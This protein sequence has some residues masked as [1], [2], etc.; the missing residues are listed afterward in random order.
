MV[1]AKFINEINAK[2]I[3]LWQENGQL[4]FKAA[5]GAWTD[6]V[7][8][9]VIA[10]KKEIIEFLCQRSQKA[11]VPAILPVTR[12][13]EDGSPI[14]SFPLSF[15][16]ER[17]W[18]IDQLEPGSTGY[19]L[20]VAVTVS[21]ELNIELLEQAFN[22]LI[23]RHESLRTVFATYEGTAQQVILE[24]IAFKLEHVDLSNHKNDEVLHQE[25][26]QL[27]QAEAA[28]PFDLSKGPLIRGKLFKLSEKEHVLMLIKHHIISDGWSMGIMIKEL[29]LMMRSL[30][31]GQSPNLPPLPVQYVDYSAW[32]RKWLGDGGLLEKQLAYWSEKLAG[33]PESLNL[34]TDYP[35]L[36]VQ[37]VEGDKHS[38]SLDTR[39]TSKL[40]SMAE[41][42]GCTL[43]MVLVAAFNALL[44]RY[45]GQ[46]DIC[47]GSPVANRHYGE[48]EGLIGLFI[49]TLAIR[50]QVKGDASFIALLAQVK[51]TCLA[52]YKHQDTPF[53]KIVDTVQP[54]RSTAINPIFQIMIGLHNERMEEL[55]ENIRRYPIDVDS[56]KLDLTLSFTEH[57]T[58]INGAV[59]YKTSLFKPQTIER[60]TKHFVNICQA[61][62]CAPEVNISS[63]EFISEAEKQLLLTE[64]NQ[65]QTSYPNDKCIHQLFSEQVKSNP[66]K[67]AVVF[68]D[69]TMSYQQL[70]DK[71]HAL[72][73][74]LQS[75]GVKPD[76]LVG[77]C[78]ERS[79]DMMV[80][81][82][83]ILQA[84]AAYLPLDPDLPDDRLTFMLEDSEAAII[85]TQE[86]LRN[87]LS[88]LASKDTKL[89]ALDQQWSE[90][91]L[92][93]DELKRKQVK[94]QQLVKPHHLAYVI[95]TSGSTGQ[96]K[97][98]MIE[99]RM[100]ID[101]CYAVFNKLD[102]QHCETFGAV[103][104]FS[105]DLGNISLFVPVMFSKTIVMFS[106]GY[107]NNPPKLKH[108]LDNNLV[109]FMKITPSHFEMFKISDSEIV[110]PAKV[111]IF[112]G[113]PL[114][115][116]MVEVVNSL[117]PGCRV[118][119]N[120]GP[121]ETTISKLSTD[122]LISD[123]ISSINLGKPLSNT[124]VYILD[125][126]KNLVPTGVPG[127]LYIA[128]EGVA[129]GY[130]NR[131]EL[132][133][134]NFLVNPFNTEAADSYS[135]MYKTGDLVRWLDDGNIEYLGRVDT[136][137]KI[138]GFRIEVGEI[139]AQ[140]NQ[141]PE[142]KESIVTVSGQDS[143]KKL[144]AYYVAKETKEG[145][146]INLV[147][148]TLRS[149]LQQ[150]LP[151]YML[152]TTF[153]SLESMPLT[154]SGKA[155]RRA[156]QYIDVS[157]ESSNAYVAPRNS[158][159]KQLVVIWADVLN[160]EEEKVGIKDNFFELGGDSIKIIQVVYSASKYDIHFDANDVFDYQ[161]I[162]E[163]V[164]NCDTT[165]SKDIVREE[166]SLQGDV[167]LSPIQS[168]FFEH[169]DKDVHHYNQAV[170]L[171]L[172][173]SLSTTDLQEIA[174]TLIQQHDALRLRY[175]KGDSGWKQYYSGSI[176]ETL[177]PEFHTYDI[178][179]LEGE[180]LA[181]YVE[182]ICN[183]WQVSL[184]LE[185]G[186]IMKWVCFE[187]KDNGCDQ[188]AIIIHHLAIDGVSWRILFD[189]FN[190]LIEQQLA[191]ESLDLDQK[192]SSYRDWVD[193]L[194]G[195]KESQQGKMDLKFWLEQSERATSS[196]S[197]FEENTLADKPYKVHDIEHTSV[198]LSK[199]D[200]ERLLKHCHQAYG[201]NINDL[202][203]TALMTSY[204]HATGNQNLTVD[205]EGHGRELL[206]PDIDITKTLGWFTSIYPVYFDLSNP[207]NIGQCIKDVKSTLHSIPSKGVGYS[208]FRYID[209]HKAIKKI[210]D[211]QVVFNFLGD[212]ST[213]ENKPSNNFFTLSK[214]SV[215]NTISQQRN[216]KSAVT[217]NG[218]VAFD[219][220]SFTFQYPKEWQGQKI[221]QWQTCF[222]SALE[223]LI[224]QCYGSPRLGFTPD[225][226]SL[227]SASPIQV[228]NIVQS[229]KQQ[230][231]TQLDNIQDIYPL[232]PLQS[233]ILF[234]T[235][236]AQVDDNKGMYLTQSVIGINDR[237]DIN[238][239][240]RAWKLIANHYDALRMM[241][242]TDDVAN[243]NTGLQVI[244]KQVD[245]KIENFDWP[246]KTDAQLKLACEQW[247]QKS[248]LSG[249]RL[250]EWPLTRLSVF[251]GCES[252]YL[253]FEQ[254]H[255]VMDGWAKN[256]VFS[257]FFKLYQALIKNKGYQLPTTARYGDYVKVLLE[258]DREQ[259]SLY[260]QGYLNHYE[261]KTPLPMQ[262]LV[263]KH[264]DA[265]AVF[266]T[267]SFSFS[268]ENTNRLEKLNKSHRL[269]MNTL[270]QFIWGAL[271]HL[272]SGKKAV[273][274]GSVSSGR[275]GIHHI[276]HSDQL[277]GLCINTTPTCISFD[278]ELNLLDHL[279]HM[280]ER[281]LGKLNFESTPLVDIQNMLGIKTN[282]DFFQTLFVYENYP[283]EK[284]SEAEGMIKG[285]FGDDAPNY[286][287]SIKG[288]LLESLSMT[289]AWD[290]DYFDEKTINSLMQ[291]FERLTLQLLADPEQTIQ[292]V[293][294]IS[295]TEK[296]L[297][298]S[299][300]KQ[301]TH[302]PEDK[303]I[304]ELFQQQVACYP[305]NTA[306][307]CQNEALSYQQLYERSQALALY[308]RSQGVKPDTL[309]GLCV[310]RSLD[311]LVGIMG[312]LQAGGAYVPMD[313][314]TPDDRLAYILQDSQTSIVLTQEKLRG[315]LSTFAAK[316]TQ[317]IA[318]DDQWSEISDS[319][320]TLNSQQLALQQAV[321]PE[322]LAYVI[323]TSGSTG[324]PKGVMVTHHNVCRLF[325][326]SRFGFE[327]GSDDVWTLFHSFSFD[328]SVWEI[329]GALFHGGR[330][331]IVPS[332]VTRATEDFYKLVQEEQVTVL[333]QTPSAF[334][335]FINVDQ[336]KSAPLSLRYVIFGG[337]ALNFASLAPW[338]QRHGDVSPQLVNMYG[339][340]ET[341]VHVTYQKINQSVIHKDK[342]S[343]VIGRPL[344]DLGIAVLDHRGELAPVGVPGELHV[345][346]GGV[347][348]GY[349]NRPELTKERFVPKLLTSDTSE[350]HPCMYKT[351]DLVCWRDDGN[352]EYLGRIDTQVKIRGF[353]IELGE[354]E[355]QLNQHPDIKDSTVIVREHNGNKHLVAYYVAEN[356]R[357]EQGLSLLQDDLHKWLHQSLPGYM[358][359]AAFVSLETIPLT[360]NG[361]VDRRRLERMDV[362]LESS[363]AYLAPRN[364]M[365]RQLVAIWAEVL[366]QDPEKIGVNDNFFELGGH[367]LLATQ[368][369]AKI[370]S[371]LN[372][373]V[374][375]KALFSATTLADVSELVQAIKGQYDKPQM[376]AELAEEDFEEV[377]L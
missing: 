57:P 202:L 62:T 360:T 120:Y 316:D 30:Q 182:A 200:T 287:L 124:Q 211:A 341:T 145:H 328:F 267:A 228:D 345:W 374:P 33:V 166:G 243:M 154:P 97:G 235:L 227:L 215:G 174:K 7:R 321:K 371:Q 15:A 165:K 271:L 309:V 335:E 277:V 29:G 114:S 330:L 247:Q 12:I 370:R 181:D 334:K 78:V 121:T 85:L 84:G 186:P 130:L 241:V 37:S 94:L 101:Y 160:V 81:I 102:L 377:S 366:D 258:R 149:W 242:F 302:Y 346:G 269:T 257:N 303:C 288:V 99:H 136:Q 283:V 80:G 208:I 52:A 293:S 117:K 244:L 192:G 319:V 278:S 356:S 300:G 1:I 157:L 263:A 65:T 158:T 4:K 170:L 43:Y 369:I 70:Y 314:A 310:E 375:M 91:S 171:N 59:S 51:S 251:Q 125:K 275:A 26:Q 237:V 128:G 162:Q 79:S 338:M 116:E 64:Y 45:T 39:L 368:V 108:Y 273:T 135:R 191:N 163:L 46:E 295:E 344:T 122:E 284:I 142:I 42:N 148:E 272:H 196:K 234:E 50:N 17:L 66:G 255:I 327:F 365:E 89:I 188:L 126:Y 49:N 38:F 150:S 76:T 129:R 68:H 290:S 280:Q 134:E 147:N 189:D 253:L 86:K 324:K 112:A 230:G 53:E 286:P 127:E 118:F 292:T 71:S 83:G 194:A 199:F 113:E 146:V 252:S 48:T 367:S 337:E 333:N 238:V 159:E 361:K 282:E 3:K 92:F 212:F 152:P 109:D 22:L 220:L 205:L 195:Y 291:Q 198:Q 322:H 190:R 364:E 315:K 317:L 40:K 95:Y 184:N 82:L 74:Y 5:K 172:N 226:F 351:G 325:D 224:E 207:E 320:A 229:L 123:E 239:L 58:G 180:Q 285:I 153:V 25:V 201:T 131:P 27:C 138:R 347:T 349:L 24:H 143:Q 178:S 16:Q 249:I 304:H 240:Q 352:L 256:I 329:W 308:L 259:E 47:V 133:E 236:Y 21:G 223:T 221:S 88:G 2:G 20:P 139:E 151:D 218:F 246:E 264:K 299:Y 161:S 185:K 31:L 6:E 119:N 326:S 173:V 90:I 55:A 61:I 204:Y 10:N 14:E 19:S 54:Q 177:A 250:D 111:L 301:Q 93:A 175:S 358:L 11:D 248:K 63:L 331:V 350:K 297:Q 219:Q 340:T 103:S 339:I 355:A 100:V 41:Q 44:Y 307:V 137:V 372:I 75:L 73:L 187:A 363:Q 179:E 270:L 305:N 8:E 206:N 56:S 23:A 32:Q 289:F 67:K 216:V 193:S 203:L 107:V 311:M 318:L 296:Q 110:A 332:E 155:D 276:Q 106:K 28:T 214:N 168:R 354:I 312:I 98:V 245:I 213:N 357:E 225:D 274:F 164:E 9:K 34:A 359:P 348:R 268:K 140:L 281:E 222:I 323:Y 210:S 217:I 197:F 373:D 265:K 87:K 169:A 376:D 141:H 167:K 144:I 132:T 342:A 96:P 35:R 279:K 13:K 362:N 18:F 105:A 231:K 115:K 266:K 261:E 254:H 69:E 176:D 294:L 156:L 72:A 306:V 336:A 232:T 298:T 260:W 353:R 313:P 343:S 77:L 262:H 233:G 183:Q 104:T 60:L 209:Q 36:S